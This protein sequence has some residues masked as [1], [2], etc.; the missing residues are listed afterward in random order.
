MI[1]LLV[2]V[3]DDGTGTGT[4]PI[5]FLPS[6]P[7][8]ALPPNP[9]GME[10]RYFATISDEDNLLGSDRTAALEAIGSEGFY[11]AQRLI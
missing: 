1:Q 3:S 9:R 4:G 10:W 8:A 7:D 5:L 11:I 6:R 2:F